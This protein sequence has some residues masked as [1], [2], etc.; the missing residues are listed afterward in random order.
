MVLTL[1]LDSKKLIYPEKGF[2]LKSDSMKK[3]IYTDTFSTEISWCCKYKYTK[4]M[5]LS[6]APHCASSLCVI[7][8]SP[9]S[10]EH[11]VQ[12]RLC[13]TR[14]DLDISGYWK[15]WV[16]HNPG[17]AGSLRFQAGRCLDCHQT[18]KREVGKC[19]ISINLSY[20]CFI[21]WTPIIL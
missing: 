5:K 3:V 9:A 19:L 17:S 10:L 6:P 11:I 15:E 2:S 4:K 8:L 1:N 13:W 12:L 14:L 16:S 21:Y 7:P 18:C 20:S